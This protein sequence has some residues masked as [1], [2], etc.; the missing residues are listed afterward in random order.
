MARPAEYDR[1]EVLERAMQAFW[2]AGYCATSMSRLTRATRLQPGSLYAAFRSKEGLFLEALDHYGQRSIEEI[3]STLR[4]Y[5]NPLD[6]IREVVRHLAD[7]TQA[8]GKRRGC[9]L[10]KTVLEMAGQNPR[11]SE[12]AYR[13]LKEIEGLFREA[14]EDA[15]RRGYL[16]EHKDPSALATFIMT[17]IWGLR[18]LMAADPGQRASRAVVDQ[19][20]SMLTSP[21]PAVMG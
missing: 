1:T 19:L 4:S 10:V 16:D 9:L 6:G 13:H 12:R 3:G 11:A 21:T 2:E 14:L 20:S 8:D 17:T 7:K 18:V 15:Q 5:E